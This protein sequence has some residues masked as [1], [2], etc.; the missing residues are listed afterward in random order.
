MQDIFAVANCLQKVLSN[1]VAEVQI[2][3]QMAINFI[4]DLDAELGPYSS[5]RHTD[6]V[7][8]QKTRR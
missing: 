4:P 5:I 1:E 6:T 7:S 3:T 2:E 8:K